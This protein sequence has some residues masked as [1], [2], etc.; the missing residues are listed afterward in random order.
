MIGIAVR[1]LDKA[2]LAKLLEELAVPDDEKL[3]SEA[4]QLKP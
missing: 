1:S 4:F 2:G 3:Q